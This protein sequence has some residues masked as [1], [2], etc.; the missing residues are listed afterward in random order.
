M[1]IV[2]R[3]SCTTRS[4]R[5]LGATCSHMLSV[6]MA[7]SF[8]SL[9]TVEAFS[10]NSTCLAIYSRNQKWELENGVDEQNRGNMIVQA[11]RCQRQE[12]KP[13][14][15][16]SIRTRYSGLWRDILSSLGCLKFDIAY[17]GRCGSPLNLWMTSFNYVISFFSC[18]RT[19]IRRHSHSFF[20]AYSF[21][22]LTSPKG[23]KLVHGGIVSA[24]VIVVS[25]DFK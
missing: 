11:P 12:D 10:G 4:M 20:I 2:E 5:K 25:C 19:S 22:V 16:T 17:C 13:V 23:T 9:S 7:S 6:R 8:I 15:I 3:Q 14:F 24:V 21:A 1:G 18:P